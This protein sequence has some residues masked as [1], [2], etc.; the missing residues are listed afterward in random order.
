MSNIVNVVHIVLIVP[1]VHAIPQTEFLSSETSLL[2]RMRCG[3]AFASSD[4]IKIGR[5]VDSLCPQ[6]GAFEDSDPI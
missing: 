1:I 6:Y 5:R 4:L 2:H 3:S